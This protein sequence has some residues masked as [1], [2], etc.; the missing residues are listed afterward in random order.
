[1]ESIVA[2]V[3]LVL[4]A[5][6]SMNQRFKKGDVQTVVDRIFPLAAHFDD[7]GELD[8]WT[9]AE[10]CLA[11]SPVSGANLK[12]YIDREKG[13]WKLWRLGA[14]QN[15]EP[16]AIRAVIDAFRT[17]KLPTYVLF[18]SDGGVRSSREIERLI[19]EASNLP[20]FWQFVGLGGDNYGILERL[21]SMSGRVVDNCN[22]F[23]LDD[24]QSVSEQELYERLLGEFPQWLQEA[25]TKKIIPS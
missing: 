16:D 11:L 17:S 4:D 15:F 13:G 8:V 2:R 14:R 9:F 23:A 25:R 6:G 3:A 22:F 20:I 12:G 10:T 7:N 19:V 21:D 5:S 1:L 24:I 18:I